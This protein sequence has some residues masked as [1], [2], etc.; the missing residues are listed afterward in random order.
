M[1][2]IIFVGGDGT[3]RAVD[4]VVGES[5][6]TV[7]V[8]N[9]I[10]GIEGECGGE[11]AC[12]TCH[13]R[14]TQEWRTEVGDRGA[15]ETDMIEDLVVGDVHPDSRLGCQIL[16]RPELDGLRISVPGDRDEL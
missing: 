4:A 11:M 1:P 2:K 9:D 7:A 6:M 16:V 15:E 14:V 10:S 3:E 5:L 8:N 12:G 13:I